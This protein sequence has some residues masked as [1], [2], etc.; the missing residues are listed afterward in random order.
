MRVPVRCFL[1]LLMLCLSARSGPCGVPADYYRATLCGLQYWDTMGRTIDW[2][3]LGGGWDNWRNQVY[4]PGS[5]VTLYPPASDSEQQADWWNLY[6]NESW[7]DAQQ[8]TGGVLFGVAQSGGLLPSKVTGYLHFSG[9][10]HEFVTAPNEWYFAAAF[11]GFENMSEA[12]FEHQF[13]ISGGNAAFS[14]DHWV[15]WYAA[16]WY[17]GEVNGQHYDDLLVLTASVDYGDDSPVEA[18]PLAFSGLNPATTRIG[19]KYVVADNGNTVGFYYTINDQ[20]W[21]FHYA[22]TLP[23]GGRCVGYIYPDMGLR[24][25][26]TESSMTVPGLTVTSAAHLNPAPASVPM[27]AVNLLLLLDDAPGESEF[28]G[29]QVL[30][31][32]GQYCPPQLEV[33]DIGNDESKKLNEE[34]YVYAPRGGASFTG[35]DF[36]GDPVTRSIGLESDGLHYDGVGTWAS[37]SSMGWQTHVVFSE[38]QDGEGTFGGSMTDSEERYNCG[39]VTGTYFTDPAQS[40]AAFL[41]AFDTTLH[42]EKCGTLSVVLTLGDSTS[43]QGEQYYLYVGSSGA[44]RAYG[45]DWEGDRIRETWARRYNVLMYEKQGV[46]LPNYDGGWTDYVVF[47]F[48]SDLGGGTLAGYFED[49]DTEAEC[50][51]FSGTFTRR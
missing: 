19:L 30:R 44:G 47:T 8:T 46:Y 39:T 3:G 17:T 43:R 28:Y 1:V 34:N 16:I 25:V 14:D 35:V 20:A 26:Q 12:G 22:S 23:G 51:T 24:K 27:A 7:A 48:D 32:T 13:A 5:A 21:T 41:G 2:D 18:P 33:V 9:F 11:K 15:P 36:E 38:P 4:L 45:T 42:T 6:V 29:R 10:N 31:Y 40:N 37:D 49:T 50:G